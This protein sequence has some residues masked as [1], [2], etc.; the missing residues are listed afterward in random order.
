MSIF[1]FFKRKNNNVAGIATSAGTT[2]ANT[3]GAKA[4]PKKSLYDLISKSI[5]DGELPRSFFAAGR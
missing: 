3:S 5:V 1:D 2:T 4:E